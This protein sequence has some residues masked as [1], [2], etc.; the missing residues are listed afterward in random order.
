MLC[1]QEDLNLDLCDPSVDSRG[2]G[3]EE[4]EAGRSRAHWSAWLKQ[5]ILDLERHPASIDRQSDRQT[6]R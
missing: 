6:D 3:V 5:Q 1:K 2:G 4:A